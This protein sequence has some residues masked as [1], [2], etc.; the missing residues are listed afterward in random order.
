MK[1]LLDEQLPVKLYRDFSPEHEACTSR[2]MGWL[3]KQNGELLG[4]MNIHGFDGLVTN[5]KNL[6]YQQNLDRFPIRYFVLNSPTNNIQDHRV[7]IE[8]LKKLLKNLPDR[9]VIELEWTS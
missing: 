2:Y 9:Q 4:L 7:Q 3:G 1:L 6:I 8:K 5:D